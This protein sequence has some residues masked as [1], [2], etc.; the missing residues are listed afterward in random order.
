M[1]C[2]PSPQ[3]N[4]PG[5]RVKSRRPATR[6]PTELIS[7]ENAL[8]DVDDAPFVVLFNPYHGPCGTYAIILAP[9]PWEDFPPQSPWEDNVVVGW[10]KAAECCA[11]AHGHASVEAFVKSAIRAAVARHVRG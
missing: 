2:S 10:N 8:P 5:Q 3:S 11:Q 6:M 4:P 7:P 9:F 1:L